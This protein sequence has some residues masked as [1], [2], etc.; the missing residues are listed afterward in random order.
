MKK[1]KK[2]AIK[3]VIMK[4]ENKIYRKETFG[5]EPVPV[6]SERFSLFDGDTEAIGVWGL[7]R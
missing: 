2:I 1:T 7:S 5:L 4:N 3:N 6:H